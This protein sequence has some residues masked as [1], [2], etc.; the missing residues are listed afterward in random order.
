MKFEETLKN[1]KV[2]LTEG[3]V[4][5]RLNRNDA[6][7]LDPY[8]VHAGLIYT[9][10]GNGILSEIYRE[11]LD[12]GRRYNLPMMVSAP[13]WR[14][15]PERIG[16]SIFKTYENI[17]ADCVSFIDEIRT[18][19]KSKEAKWNSYSENGMAKK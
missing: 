19:L 16:K 10:S 1:S 11:Y 5:E 6:I 9:D 7:Q 4:I 3:A 12:I 14:A 18:L 17:N 13:T 2:I 15:N 8:I